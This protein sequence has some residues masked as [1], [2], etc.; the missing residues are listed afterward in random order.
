MESFNCQYGSLLA[1]G[2]ALWGSEEVKVGFG[3]KGGPLYI[4]H[5]DYTVDVDPYL[6]K[7]RPYP[8]DHERFKFDNALTSI[9]EPSIIFTANN[10]DRIAFKAQLGYAYSPGAY[11]HD[12]YFYQRFHVDLLSGSKIHPELK[13]VTISIG[14]SFKL[15]KRK[16]LENK[17]SVQP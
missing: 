2:C 12:Y 4:Y 6:G 11:Q 5:Y 1:S 16:V 13:P 10:R 8:L 15:I 14:V 9:W 17:E 3:F 7:E